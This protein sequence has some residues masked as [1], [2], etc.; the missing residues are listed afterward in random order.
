[1]ALLF[2]DGFDAGDF[3]QKGWSGGSSSTTTR[4]GSGRSLANPGRLKFTASAQIIVGFAAVTG[5]TNNFNGYMFGLFTDGGSIAHL[6][7][8]VD[9]SGILVYKGGSI[10]ATGALPGTFNPGLWNYYE[11][12]ATIATTGGTVVVRVNGQTVVNFTGN[13]RNG[14]TSTN[15]DAIAQSQY[16]AAS[17]Y[18]DLY[19]CDATGPA[20]WNTFLGD[21]RV[22]T[23]T[24]NGAGSSTQFTASSGANYTTVNEL[25]FSASQYVQSGTV[26][27]RDTYTMADIPA[28]VSSVLGV[29]NNIITKKTDTGPMNAKPAIVSGGNVYYGAAV[30]L[31]G[32]DV[33][34][35]DVRNINPATGAQWSVTDV[36]NLE[37]GAEVG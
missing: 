20:P 22:L 29:Q 2:M 35:V 15:I 23:S 26:G 8:N 17:T 24:P 12:S 34:V 36:N 33:T 32:N 16:F 6:L 18:D 21:V 14:G 27:Q 1:M 19:V 25:P 9:V 37:A 10:I 4:F 28:T 13:T 31:T 30:P 7:F 3:I 5:Y 11:V